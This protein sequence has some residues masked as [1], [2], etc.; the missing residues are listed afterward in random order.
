VSRN[1]AFEADANRVIDEGQEFDR[2]I[3]KL[4][5]PASAATSVTPQILHLIASLLL[6]LLGSTQRISLQLV[7]L[8]RELKRRDVT[9]GDERRARSVRAAAEEARAA[10]DGED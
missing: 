2:A 10:D 4:G 9:D 3:V 6:L 5:K 7:D 1:D 8:H